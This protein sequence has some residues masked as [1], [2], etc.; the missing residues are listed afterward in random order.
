MRLTADLI[1]TVDQRGIFDVDGEGQLPREFTLEEVDGEWRIANPPDGL[2]MLEPDFERLYDRRLAY[3]LDPT[4]TRVVPDP[5]YLIS[6][7]AQ[8]TALLN[9]VLE[10]PSAALSAGVRNPLSGG[11]VQLRSAVTVNGTRRPSST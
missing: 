11:E 5:R 1:G 10:G 9:R 2:I 6:G 4:G 8:P 7:E 3:F